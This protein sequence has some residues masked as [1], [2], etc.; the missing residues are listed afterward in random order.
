MLVA[1]RRLQTAEA[2]AG[3]EDGRRMAGLRAI[4]KKEK[5]EEGGKEKGRKGILKYSE[6]QGNSKFR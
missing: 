1:N 6:L 4:L 3:S 2:G 5:R